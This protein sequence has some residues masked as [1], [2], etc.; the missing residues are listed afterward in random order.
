MTI[1]TYIL[2]TGSTWKGTAITDATSFTF[3][4]SSSPTRISTDG[5]RS[6]G[7]IVV[8]QKVAT[9]TVNGVNAVLL[10]TA[11]FRAGQNGSLVLKTK[12]RSAGDSVSTIKTFT[13]A[14]SVLVSNNASAP[15]EG[16]GSV[17]LTFEAYD[18]NDDATIFAV[19]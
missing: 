11:A 19:S 10:A 15:N 13:F 7:L 16:N 14:E 8:D 6:V 1:A 4:E 3:S 12:L 9:I 5:S 18:T 17:A 2:E